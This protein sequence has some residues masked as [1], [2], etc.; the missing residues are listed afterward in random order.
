M[1]RA[2]CALP[3]ASRS[4]GALPLVAPRSRV[5]PMAPTLDLSADVRDL[6]AALVDI[7]SVS[8]DED[9]ITDAVEAALNAA[10][11]GAG[12]LSIRRDGNVII[13]RT[14]LGRGARVVLAG[15]LDT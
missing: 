2:Y 13:A 3:V 12:R 15:H 1:R 10:D 4:V 6:T 9:A 7:P 14:D 5:Q 11:G 8:G